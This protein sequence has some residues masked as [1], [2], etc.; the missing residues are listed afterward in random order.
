MKKRLLLL[1][2][3]ILLLLSLSGCSEDTLLS[4]DDPVTLTMW[5]VYGEQADSPMNRLI[6]RFNST[7][8]QEKGIN[9]TV[10]NV[11]STSKINAQ[12]QT[13]LSGAPGSPEAPD[14]FS[15]HTATAASFDPAALLDWQDYFSEEELSHFVPQFLADGMLGEQLAVFPVSKSSYALFINGSQFARFS[16]DTG[17]TYED[18]ATWEGFFDAAEKYYAWSGGKPICAFDYLIRHVEFDIMS[19]TGGIEYTEDGWYHLEDEAV[20]ASW[21]K[22]ALPFAK[23]HIAVSDAYANTQVMTGET[24]AG[25][26]STAAVNYYNDVVTY[27]DNTSEQMALQVLPL[28]RTGEGEQ[29]MPVTGVGLCARKT[30]EQKAEAAAVFVRWLT[31]SSRNLD[32]VVET[33][34]MPVRVDAFDAMDSYDF[35]SEGHKSLYTAIRVMLEGY[36]PVVRP[37]FDGFYAK[38]EA[39]YAGLREMQPDLRARSDAGEDPLALAEETWALLASIQ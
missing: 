28:P 4:A 39:L 5:H 8:G 16:A 34:Y 32:F 7:V 1:L 25:F 31:E 27:P 19:Q 38:V 11:T 20:R 13:A 33:G 26:G 14:L 10:T 17:V 23:G 6:A 22:F 30:T 37:D 35:P 3:G 21:M 24:L 12:L 2:A 18:L 9:V 15:A 29:Y 36:T